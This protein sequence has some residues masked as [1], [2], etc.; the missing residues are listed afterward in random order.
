MDGLTALA[1]PSDFCSQVPRILM[2]GNHTGQVI[3]PPLGDRDNR[4][5]RD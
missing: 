3:A 4:V 5:L 2:S 1:F